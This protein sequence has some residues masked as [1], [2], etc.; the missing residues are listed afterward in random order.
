M[1]R[2]LAIGRLRQ[3]VQKTSGEV[4]Q[5][6]VQSQDISKVLEVIRAIAEQTTY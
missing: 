4:H 5:L 3:T 1:H 6:A 2:V